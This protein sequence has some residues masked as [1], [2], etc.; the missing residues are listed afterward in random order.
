M[1][2]FIVCILLLSLLICLIG[3]EKDAKPSDNDSSVNT[4][5]NNT[6]IPDNVTSSTPDTSPENPSPST[7]DSTPSEPASPDS[8]GFDALYDYIVANGEKQ[9]DTYVFTYKF[10]GN[11]LAMT[12]SD[13]K[14]YWNFKTPAATMDMQLLKSGAVHTVHMV[15]DAYE[16]TATIETATYDYG[17]HAI[18]NFQST[19]GDLEFLTNST[20]WGMFTT[21]TMALMKADL[22]PADLGFTSYK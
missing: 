21:A 4:S 11:T 1:K 7:D 22:T 18:S 15:H 2:R 17:T 10:S 9:E 19:G 20:A 14:I 16:S 6:S 8:K 13:G 3:C 5:E 12:A